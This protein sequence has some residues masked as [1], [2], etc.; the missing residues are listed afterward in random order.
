M[1][2]LESQSPLRIPPDVRVLLSRKALEK[3]PNDANHF[4]N[5]A[6]ASA[7]CGNFS[8]AAGAYETAARL[9]PADFEAWPTLA[10]CYVQLDLPEAALDACHRA[11]L[12]RPSANIHFQR[13]R[14]LR[15]LGRLADAQRAFL[16]AAKAPETHLEALAELFAP[17]VRNPDGTELLELCEELSQ[18]YEHTPLVR[19]HRAIALSRLGRI[20]EALQIVDLD[21]HV[22]RIPFDPPSHFG[23]I[24]KFNRQLTDDI[25]ADRSRDMGG[26]S[27]INY[28]PPF[29]RSQ[30]L[31]ALREFIKSAIESYLDEARDRRLE[32]V[33]PAPP[34][35][36]SLFA[37][38]TILRDGGHNGEHIHVR[39]YVST[40]Y[41]VSVPHSVT[42]A[43]DDR[44]ALA[45]GRCENYTGGY[46]PCWGT[47]FIKPIAGWLVIFPS[48]V[49]HDVVPSLTHTPRISVAAD[50]RPPA[51][52]DRVPAFRFAYL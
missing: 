46:V 40:V 45:L 17:M 10:R 1:R 15:K 49:Y 20:E 30:A 29:Q 50:L 6:D 34:K 11:E 9:A 43:S 36:G 31:L 19:S 37:S 22:A 12:L 33:M 51:G 16:Q 32:L 2:W 21:R 52:M 35:E 25:L 14:A 23:G 28:A 39:A 44:G 5:L 38:T 47:R 7:D 41:H 8:D 42:Q 4:A 26:N 18:P 24:E 3:Y 48:H 13:G 27:Y